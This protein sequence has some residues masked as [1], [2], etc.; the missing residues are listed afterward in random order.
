MSPI[1]DFFQRSYFPTLFECLILIQLIF[2]LQLWMRNIL[3]HPLRKVPGPLVAKVTPLW[4]FYHSWVG[5]EY[6]VIEKLHHKYGNVLRVGPNTVD[7]ADG[8]AL[9]PIYVD[10]GG[11]PKTSHYHNFYVDGFPTI[12]SSTDPAYRASKVK[13]VAPMFSNTAIR[14]GSD[15]IN[16][17][18][19]RFVNRLQETRESSA[20]HSVEL[21]EH[22]RLLGLDVLASYLFRRPHPAI[23]EKAGGSDMV[24][25]WLNV[26]VDVGQFYYIPSRLFGYLVSLWE[27]RRPDRVLEAESAITV[28]EYAMSLS[29]DVDDIEGS[30]QGRLL[31]HGFSKEEVAAESKDLTFAGVHSFGS[32][33]ATTLWY[34]AK[35]TAVYD[36]LRD[37]I[38]QSRGSELDTQHLSLLQGVVKEGLRLAPANGTRFPRVVSSSG[39]N[40]DGYYF[41]PGTIVGVSAPQLLLNEKVFPDPTIFRPERWLKPSAEMQRDFIPFSVG[42]RQCIARNLAMA[43]LSMA[44]KKVV[45]SDVLRGARPAQDKIEV[46]EWFNVAV[47]GNKIELLWATDQE[48]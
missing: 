14:Q 7:V 1:Q 17:C 24:L 41:P 6:T 20:S 38:L 39:W 48:K 29:S 8:A 4:Q 43:E 15:I 12:F 27:K 37:E 33:L 34:L 5:D 36:R 26:F 46:W 45:E 22:A 19:D 31:K 3:C 28:H 42:I 9:G 25:P 47:K 2:V 40:F 21:Q 18:V 44:V 10:K 23:T 35:D 32:V 13:L 11:F 16:Q 30:F